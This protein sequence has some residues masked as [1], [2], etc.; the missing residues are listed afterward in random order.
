M[1]LIGLNDVAEL[2]GVN[3]KTA[4]KILNMPGCPLLPRTKGE[5]YRIVKEALV[6]WLENGCPKE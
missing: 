1:E 6:R 3:V 5:Q 2:L 4:T